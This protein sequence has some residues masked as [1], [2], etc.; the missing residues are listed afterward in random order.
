MRVDLEPCGIINK[1]DQ[2]STLVAGQAVLL[3]PVDAVLPG[4]V[5]ERGVVDTQLPGD[6]GDLGDRPAAGS[7][8]L[9][10]VTVELVG[11]LPSGSLLLVG[12]LD[13][14]LSSEVSCHQGEVQD[15]AA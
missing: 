3:A 15:L 7:H 14:L 5:A 11:E 8:Q 6:L 1:K 4:S 13:S 9:D 10:R 12:H 2:P